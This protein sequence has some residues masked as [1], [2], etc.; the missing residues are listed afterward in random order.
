MLPAVV[1]PSIFMPGGLTADAATQPLRLTADGGDLFLPD[2]NKIILA[3]VNFY[4]EWYR[5]YHEHAFYDVKNL[6][7]HIPAANVVRFVALLWHDSNGEG[8]G[9]ECSTD[10]ATHG[11]IHHKCWM[12]IQAAVNQLTQAGLWVIISARAKYASGYTWPDDPDVFHDPALK[13]KFYEMWRYVAREFAN[14]D[15]IAG[16]EIMSEPRTRDVG[17]KT[18]MEFMAGGCDMV[19]EADPRA[20]CVVGPAPYYKIW[21]LD[22]NAMGLP[23]NRKNVMYTFDF[24]IPRGFVMSN[25]EEASEDGGDPPE[26][27]GRYNCKD[28][29][30]SWWKGHCHGKDDMQ[31]VDGRFLL[32]TMRDL[33]GRLRDRLNAPVYCNQWGVKDEVYR[34]AG[35]LNYAETLMETF[36]RERISSTY[37]IWR[38]YAKG[39]RDV[40]M[41]EW[42]FELVRNPGHDANGTLMPEFIDPEMT[43]TLQAGFSKINPGTPEPPCVD[44]WEG[45]ANVPASRC[46]FIAAFFP[47][48]PMPP[49]PPGSP[50]NSCSRLLNSGLRNAR[51]LNPP[52]WCYEIP[53]RVHGGCS[54]FYTATQ[55]MRVHRCEEPADMRGG[56]G[57]MCTHSEEMLCGTP[58]QPPPAQ[59]VPMMPPPPPGSPPPYPR[60]P[61]PLAPPPSPPPALPRPSPPPFM[62]FNAIEAKWQALPSSVQGLTVIIARGTLFLALLLAF[63]RL[64]S[65]YLDCVSDS[66]RAVGRGKSRRR[67]GKVSAIEIESASDSS[68]RSG[69]ASSSSKSSK[70]ST[71]KS[72]ERRSILPTRR[73][74][75]AGAGYAPVKTNPS[76][77]K[78]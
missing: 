50:P 26:F 64:A 12:Y 47:P 28:I 44:D 73:A 48:P 23:G 37:W 76:R 71:S 69:K 11:Y 16:Y 8:D 41:P 51:L 42:G 49:L 33:P 43:A 32:D 45:T 66:P 3:G 25:S 4:L 35:R 53:A 38:S 68:K 24:F 17:Q 59:P 29:Y 62:L 74:A 10:D 77:P 39:G 63:S 61:P 5:T 22:D 36:A 75:G 20:L 30:E 40:R 9:L 52:Q 60:Q 1:L 15:R 34:S 57:L 78:F 65:A 54:Q 19:H 14:T 31:T 55:D 46:R 2:G 70:G 72:A 21:M 7:R 56:Y 6:R 13:H 58:T 67:G 18:V 27:P